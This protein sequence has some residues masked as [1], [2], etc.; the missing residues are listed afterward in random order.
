MAPKP[1]PLTTKPAKELKTWLIFEQEVEEYFD[2]CGR[3]GM[4]K[5]VRLTI[6]DFLDFIEDQDKKLVKKLKENHSKATW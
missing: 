4:G 1:L 6:K 3:L 2:M 5:Q